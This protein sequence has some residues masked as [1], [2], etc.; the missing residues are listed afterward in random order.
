MRRNWSKHRV[1]VELDLGKLRQVKGAAR[2]LVAE[3]LEEGAERIKQGARRL[4]PKRTGRTARSIDK[5]REGDLSWVVTHGVGDPERGPIGMFLELG[6]RRMAPRPHLVPAL[7]AEKPELIK[8][9]ET[10]FEMM[11]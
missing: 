7:E 1:K 2:E 10:V 4:C 5:I 9:I 3:R 8:D 11:R 6:T